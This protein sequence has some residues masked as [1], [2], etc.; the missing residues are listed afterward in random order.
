MDNPGHPYCTHVCSLS[1][2]CKPS[3]THSSSC[4]CV[5][6]CASQDSAK[7][8]GNG[9][10]YK[11]HLSHRESPRRP[12]ECCGKPNLSCCQQAVEVSQSGL[13]KIT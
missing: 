6:V 5:H 4:A 10:D 8:S 1:E 9:V 2:T 7:L 3:S 11:E 12:T 13:V